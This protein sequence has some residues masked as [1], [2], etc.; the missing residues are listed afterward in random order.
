M[1]TRIEELVELADVLQQPIWTVRPDGT[2]DYANAFWRAYTGLDQAAIAG[3]GWTSAVHPD[4][5]PLMAE[6][7]NTASDSG[8]PYETEYRFRRADGSYRWHVARVAPLRGLDSSIL[9]WV[10]TA[11]DIDDRRRAEEELRASDARYRDVVDHADDIV[12]TL[13]PDGILIAVNQAVHGVLGYTPDEMIGTSIESIITPENI[14]ISRGRF[15]EKLTGDHRSSYELEVI[16]KDGRRVTLD[17]NNRLVM[18]DGRPV[19]IHG[20][21]RDISSRRERTRQAELGAAIGA[22][23]AAREPLAKRLEK[24]AEALLTHLAASYARIWTVDENDPDFLVLRAHSGESSR[25]EGARGRIPIGSWKTG[26]IAAAQRPLLTNSI[27]EDPE[28]HDR[29]WLRQKGMVAFAGFPLLVGDRL[30]GVVALFATHPFGETTLTVLSAVV[31]TIA[32]GIDRDRME[33]SR[34]QLLERE[35]VARRAAEAAEIRYRGLFEGVADAILV[36]DEHRRYSDANVAAM[37]LLGYERDELLRLRVEDVVANGPVWTREEYDRFVAGGQWQGELTLRRKDGSTV[38]IEARA[39]VVHLPEGP[40]FL[41]AIRDTTQRM[42][43]ERLQRDFLAMVTHDLRSPLTAI[44]GWT[45]MLGRRESL[46]DRAQHLVTRILAQTDQMERLISDLADLV[47]LEAGQLPLRHEPFDLVEI[48]HEQAHLVREQTEGHDIRVIASDG[49][50]V[51]VWDGRRL[52]Q[53]LQNLLANAVKY[54]PD[55]GDV[56]VCIRAVE[57]EARIEV[58]DKGVGI[59]PDHLSRL[60]E[61]FYRADATGA[62][63]LGLGLHISQ[64]LVRAH[65]GR[66]WVTSTP[67]QGSTFSVTLPMRPPGGDPSLPP[68]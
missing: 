35:K 27:H 67:G 31:D 53:V 5:I 56:L 16:A 10:G 37:T 1:S 7:W 23:L 9:R 44:K 51:G 47:R 65:H 40:V 64:M 21:A 32:L 29:E 50:V 54:S 49:P 18:Q 57:G 46:D 24:C 30:L 14:A 20:I 39:T 4:D 15:A 45:Q 8:Q 48:A 17:I 41:S 42:H 38:P 68:S 28:I 62:G 3:R 13:N 55:G 61:R 59:S 12:Y 43:L 26:R 33:A 63:G 11:I 25:P 36:A 19:V 22:T 52:G 60:F 34:E 2:V 58:A 66:I 6:G